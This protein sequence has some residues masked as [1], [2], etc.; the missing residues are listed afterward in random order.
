MEKLTDALLEGARGKG[1]D[2]SSGG[3]ESKLKA[4]DVA[5]RS[6]VGV[7]IAKGDGVD[8]AACA[9]GRRRSARTSCLPSGA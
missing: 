1:S 3:M 4:A 2:F 8:L 9:G 5:T 6:G 7:V